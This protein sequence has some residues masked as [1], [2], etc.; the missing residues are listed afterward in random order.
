MVGEEQIPGVLASLETVITSPTESRHSE[1]HFGRDTIDLIAAVSSSGVKGSSQVSSPCYCRGYTCTCT[2][3][4]FQ[5]RARPR[6]FSMTT[7]P[8]CLLYS[9]ALV[10]NDTATYHLYYFDELV[11]DPNHFRESKPFTLLLALHAQ[12]LVIVLP[13]PHPR[14]PR[15][16][17]DAGQLHASPPAG[18][19]SSAHRTFPSSKPALPTLVSSQVVVSSGCGPYRS[20]AWPKASRP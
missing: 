8:T 16:T 18:R 13:C 19:V 12:R 15:R 9:P 4:R 2:T 11:W 3:H 7:I 17:V 20:P 5:L 1:G 10:G 14:I 6:A